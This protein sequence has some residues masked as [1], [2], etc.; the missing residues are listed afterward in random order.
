MHKR[1][2]SWPAN[3]CSQYVYSTIVRYNVYL[4]IPSFPWRLGRC[5]PLGATDRC[6]L[7]SA[8]VAGFRYAFKA[9]NGNH[10]CM[11]VTRHRG[12]QRWKCDSTLCMRSFRLLAFACSLSVGTGNSTWASIAGFNDHTGV[13]KRGRFQAPGNDCVAVIKTYKITQNTSPWKIPK[14]KSTLNERNVPQ[15]V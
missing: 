9:A 2:S 5:P 6:D 15:T 4:Y 7:I 11:K 14:S 8:A 10:G 13:F 12:N 1:H 3:V